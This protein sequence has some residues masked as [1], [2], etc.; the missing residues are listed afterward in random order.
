MEQGIK[1]KVIV[2][3]AN[4][5]DNPLPYVPAFVAWNEHVEQCAPCARV[6]QLARQGT[7]VDPVQLCEGGALLQFTVGRRIEQQ[8]MISLQN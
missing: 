8:H 1:I 3:P 5:V 2:F 7:P 6:D 4:W